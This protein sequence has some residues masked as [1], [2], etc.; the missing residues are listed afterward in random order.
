MIK[1]SKSHILIQ[2]DQELINVACYPEIDVL[3]PKYGMPLLNNGWLRIMSNSTNK[4]FYDKKEIFEADKNV[5]IRH[6]WNDN[7]IRKG[8]SYYNDFIFYLKNSGFY[9]YICRK[10]KYIC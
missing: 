3:L 9:S 7:P 1:Y 8:T 5:T 6:Y 10:L 4:V 2:E